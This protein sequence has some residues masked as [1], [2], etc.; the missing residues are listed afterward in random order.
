MGFFYPYG[1]DL[2][3]SNR[4]DLWSDFILDEGHK[5]GLFLNIGQIIR[6]DAKSFLCI[7]ICLKQ[8]NGV[9]SD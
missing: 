2:I 9:E 5:L 4:K 8:R 6:L 7:S 1:A 3:S